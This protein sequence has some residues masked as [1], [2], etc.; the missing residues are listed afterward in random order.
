M[1][2][3]KRNVVHSGSV[4]SAFVDYLVAKGVDFKDTVLDDNPGVS[5]L[6]RELVFFHK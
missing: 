5:I 1:S 4:I 3:L 2:L 6:F